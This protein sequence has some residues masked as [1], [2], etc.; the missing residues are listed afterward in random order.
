MVFIFTAPE[1]ILEAAGGVL[2]DVI[3]NHYK[4]GANE[5]FPNKMGV[6][7]T[8]KHIDHQKLVDKLP[9]EIKNILSEL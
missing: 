6:F 3:G 8:A 1:A 7:A 5:L 4:Y 9:D 2:T